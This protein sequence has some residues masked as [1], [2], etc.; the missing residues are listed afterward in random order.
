MEQAREQALEILDVFLAGAAGGKGPGGVDVAGLVGAL[1]DLKA[2][3]Q[4][5]IGPAVRAFGVDSV[6]DA[7]L[8]LCQH[9][10]RTKAVP[11]LELL[12]LVLRGDGA[13]AGSRLS[14]TIRTAAQAA[15]MSDQTIRKAA[16]ECLVLLH[17]RHGDAV[18]DACAPLM[19]APILASLRDMI[20]AAP[21]PVVAVSAPTPVK[22]AKE[23]K[24]N[25]PVAVATTITAAAAPVV[26]VSNDSFASSLSGLSASS[27]KDRLAALERVSDNVSNATPE[28]A[29]HLLEE[30]LRLQSGLTG[31]SHSAVAAKSASLLCACVATAPEELVVDLS[32]RVCLTMMDR[33]KDN[34]K[35]IVSAAEDVLHAVPVNASD[36]GELM[37]AGL[38][39]TIPKARQRALEWLLHLLQENDKRWL[40][41]ALRNIVSQTGEA[42]CDSSAD[43]R[44]AAG[45]LLQLL[46]GK[47][48]REAVNAVLFGESGVASRM[49]AARQNQVKKLI[50]EAPEVFSE[51]CFS[52]SPVQIRAPSPAAKTRVASPP[53]KMT[54]VTKIAAPASSSSSSSSRS[55]PSTQIPAAPAVAR[56]APATT[57]SNI[58]PPPTKKSS[59]PATMASVAEH[60]A[61]DKSTESTL[62]EWQR[63]S[64]FVESQLRALSAEQSRTAALAQRCKAAEMENATLREHCAELEEVARLLE[65]RAVELEEEQIQH[66]EG[67]GALTMDQIKE[68][69]RGKF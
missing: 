14:N 58:A 57:A 6:L 46:A 36:L 21:A 50:A 45:T 29:G 40:R 63:M 48:G 69:R 25:A 20:A 43:V 15:Q 23:N 5:W 55:L 39:N 34:N 38:A 13:A 33:L 51:D 8:P 24:E 67:G 28:Q 11:A 64:G 54:N 49:G 35:A 47:W 32:K 31:D 3:G 66:Q 17:G 9:K 65:D 68:Q 30:L 1:S 7:L 42:M 18:L 22:K 19:R 61:T 4:P 60:A 12:Q 62:K 37:S 56:S 26:T 52:P 41:P 16:L 27:W 53:P 44:K 59:A 2:R 10:A